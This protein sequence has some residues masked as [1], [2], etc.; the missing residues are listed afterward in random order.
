MLHH[1]LNRPN[2]PL[3]LFAQRPTGRLQTLN[4][5]RTSARYA[6]AAEAQHKNEYHGAV[7]DGGFGCQAGNPFT[8]IEVTGR[9]DF[10]MKEGVIYKRPAG[11]TA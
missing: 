5:G 3:N 7:R 10:V 11:G 6:R 4:H 9:V 1:Q 8:D 2:Q